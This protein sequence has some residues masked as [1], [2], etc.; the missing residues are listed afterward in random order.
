MARVL[1][2]TF[3]SREH[4]ATS[5]HLPAI[6]RPRLYSEIWFDLFQLMGAKSWDLIP[7]TRGAACLKERSVIRRD[8][9]KDKKNNN[10]A[11]RSGGLATHSTCLSVGAS[12]VT[13]DKKNNN[14]AAIRSGGL[15][16]HNTCLSVGACVAMWS[17]ALSV[18]NGQAA[19]DSD[20]RRGQL[21]TS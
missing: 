18:S 19:T 3:D 8:A 16:T 1:T 20:C 6:D 17:R 13:E 7:E 4:P 2:P 9:T 15:A 21:S 10:A 14:S 11:I 12:V 5:N